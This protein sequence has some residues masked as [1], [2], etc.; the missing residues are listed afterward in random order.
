MTIN[1]VLKK[2]GSWTVTVNDAMPTALLNSIQDFAHL[3]VVPGRVNPVDLG[4]D[5]LDLARHVGIIRLTTDT[6]ISGV[7]LASW[8]GD[9]DKKGAVYETPI[10][11]TGA[12]FPNAIRALLPSCVQEGTLYSVPGTYT[13]T[14][15]YQDPRTAIDYVCDA[16]GADWRITNRCK[17]DA[18]LTSDLFVTTPST[19]IVRKGAGKDLHL[20]ALPGTIDSAVDA[21]DWTARVL[22]LAEGN[23]ST[24]ATGSA[25]ISINPYLDM[26]GNPVKMTRMISE[27]TTSTGNAESRAQLQL[28]R[29]SK[30]KRTVSLSAD[31]F[32]IAG[33]IK[34][35]DYVWVYDP[36]SGLYDESNEIPFRGQLLN[37]VK[38]RVQGV[39]YPVEEGSTVA[40]RSPT[41][42][43]TDLTQYIAFE[44][45]STTI[46]VGD[47]LATSL[48]SDAEAVQPRVAGDTTPPA[49]PTISSITTASYLS[50][51]GQTKAR[52]TISWNLPLNVDGSTI[53]DGDHYVVRYRVHG[54]SI[55]YQYMSVSWATR[56]VTIGELT[57]GLQYDVSVEAVDV[58]SNESGYNTDLTVIA[59][60]DTIPPST[61]DIAIVFGNP[62]S[63]QVKHSLGKATG[64]QFNLENDI[65]FLFVYADPSPT[66][67]PSV[68]N[69]VGR[70]PCGIGNLELAIPALGSFSVADGSTK[71]VK[72][73]AVDTSGNESLPSNSSVSSGLLIDTANIANAAITEALIHDLAVTNEKVSSLSATKITAGTINADVIIG[74]TL[75]TANSGVRVVLRSSNANYMYWETGDPA[76]QE[77][78]YIFGA[79]FFPGTNQR[80]Y[81]MTFKAPTISGGVFGGSAP[82]LNL[83]GHSFDQ[84]SY[85]GRVE[86][87]ADPNTLLIMDAD[88][89]VS[90]Q[91]S[92]EVALYMEHAG[93]YAQLKADGGV[94]N[95]QSTNNDAYAQ[96]GLGQAYIQG[97]GGS[98]LNLAGAGEIDTSN[99]NDFFSIVNGGFISFQVRQS[100]GYTDPRFPNLF[101]SSTDSLLRYSGLSGQ[102]FIDSSTLKLKHDVKDFA[103][104]YSVDDIDKV[105][106]VSYRE[107]DKTTDTD[108][109]FDFPG[110]IAEELHEVWPALVPLDA[111]GEPHG[112]NYDKLIAPAIAA[113]QDLR[114]RLSKVESCVESLSGVPE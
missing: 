73:T 13:N 101:P 25:D 41:G 106:V 43:W 100:A 89:V 29:F 78:A 33:D 26:F 81:Q 35:G 70:I 27:S 32:D 14:H 17:L 38:I 72:V 53:V 102:L 71:Y 114:A 42:E 98:F 69:F 55:Y 91:A 2:P 61:P 90:L 5:T 11:I 7:G 76:Q 88:D 110:V 74:G 107:M 103:D 79:Q 105:R 1:A 111:D 3:V 64:G 50:T 93:R 44:T 86:L 48:V 51:N 62:L 49:P 94:V 97:R 85:P 36:G 24:I 82:Y 45:G 18:G 112:V 20:Q 22:L 54:G 99:S 34:P 109:G 56:N 92:P 59:S 65:A 30:P 60:P 8:L 58:S 57:N 31:E 84:S 68:A 9:E 12:T 37:P 28:N 47:N 21:K 75:A 4:D 16:F 23:G 46:D 83:R 113:I 15:Q 96:I 95:I 40:Y 39:S 52:M 104:S 67:T 63:I 66:F 19:I 108:K 6:T 87:V 77:P 80:H 10:V